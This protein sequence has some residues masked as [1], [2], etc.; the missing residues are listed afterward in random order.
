[1][2]PREPVSGP[3]DEE[4]G[5]GLAWGRPSSRALSWSWGR[6]CGR[7]WRDENQGQRLAGCGDRVGE[8]WQWETMGSWKAGQRSDPR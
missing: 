8:G 6:E 7:H 4:L 2:P 5:L 3:G 1:M